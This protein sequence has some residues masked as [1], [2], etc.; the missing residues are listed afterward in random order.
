MSKESKVKHLISTNLVGFGKKKLSELE[1]EVLVE[2]CRH[3]CGGCDEDADV[4]AI[5]SALLKYKR[6]I[7]AKCAEIEGGIF[8]SRKTLKICAFNTLKLRL[9][10]ECLSEQWRRL[11]RAFADMD[12]LVFSEV[13][14]GVEWKS[15][16]LMPFLDL[17]N[18]ISTEKWLL[19]TSEES[20]GEIHTV[21][22][23]GSCKV[24]RKCTHTGLS[25]TYSPFT[26]LI[27]VN[28]KDAPLV[29]VTSVH[30]PPESKRSLRDD[31]IIKFLKHYDFSTT[32]RLDTPLTT[33]GAHDSQHRPVV[34][35]LA[36]DWNV[37]IGKPKYSP[38]LS[39]YEVLL[40]ENI[41]TTSGRRSFDNFLISRNTRSN[42]MISSSVL[43]FAVPQNSR[44]R[45]IGLSDHSPIL[46]CLKW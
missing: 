22:T 34:H 6:T 17:I 36:G 16:R 27:D 38:F 8:K 43:E 46:L 11:I 15:R 44:M 41:T 32:H 20:G 12:V 1:H 37:W 30:M 19:A 23:K 28:D 33:K 7:S 4:D 18:E 2:L 42:F 14:A 40:G 3:F 26:V 35:V 39:N 9:E 25:L 21:F 45:T 5:V 24:I 29:A 13:H 31:E 10:K